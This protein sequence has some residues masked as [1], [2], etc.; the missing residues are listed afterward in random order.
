MPA[1]AQSSVSRPLVPGSGTPAPG[2][3]ALA[4]AAL[5]LIWGSMYYAAL[6]ALET[7]PPY[8]MMAVRLLLA[9]ALLAGIGR[10]RGQPLTL[11]AGWPRNAVSGVLIMALGSGSVVW[12]EQY[13]PSSLAAMLATTIPLWL[14]VLD[15]P[16]WPRY[17]REKGP[18]LGLM[19]GSLGVVGL[20]GERLQL[21]ALGTT[22]W[23][24]VAA[25]VAGSLCS[26]GGALLTRYWPAPGPPLRNAAVQLLAAGLFCGLV[27]AGAGEW[28]HF[29][30]GQVSSRSAWAVAYAVV[31]GSGVTYLAYLWLLQVRPPAV[32]GTY[33]YVNPVVAVLLGAVLAHEPISRQQL[34][35]LLVVLAGVWLVSRPTGSGAKA[36]AP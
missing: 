32:V 7:L 27:S 26:A 22:Y 6:V 11:R 5:Y 4:F 3:V 10:L 31:L 19:L 24:A 35:A 30:P 20:L 25:V 21:P 36:G 9:G 23:L 1:T 15:R 8:L 17:R 29:S 14:A 34:L 2:A 12:A 13:L 18:L 33:A 28:S 16:R